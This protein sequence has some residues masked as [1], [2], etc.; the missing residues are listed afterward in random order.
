M[1]QKASVNIPP[2]N[3]N[4]YQ[5]LLNEMLGLI[6]EEKLGTDKGLPL[7]RKALRLAGN[8]FEGGTFY[9]TL[10]PCL[11]CQPIL[12]ELG[13]K[14][15]IYAETHPDPQRAKLWDQQI[16]EF[17]ANNQIKVTRVDMSA[18]E[19]QPNKF[20]AS[21]VTRS[22][23]G[24]SRFQSQ[25]LKRMNSSVGEGIFSFESTANNLLAFNRSRI[26]DIIA[27]LGKVSAEDSQDLFDILFDKSVDKGKLKVLNQYWMTEG[28]FSYL[29]ALRNAT[30]DGEISDAIKNALI[31][32]ADSM[33][34]YGH[35]L[36]SKEG[37][38]T[39]L[40]SEF[41]YITN[42]GPQ[43]PRKAKEDP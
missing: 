35:I 12:K 5:E 26:V 37:N 21:I 7:L 25:F 30:D 27:F 11:S 33:R 15:I 13:L 10:M 28:Y 1:L 4:T 14:K 3:Q 17:A 2:S 31:Q 29:W 39:R 18:D 32:A 38:R 43:R 19:I 23:E 36:N 8:P 6:K 22:Q 41:G 40:L 20:F 24:H 9:V 42:P 16:K 34:A